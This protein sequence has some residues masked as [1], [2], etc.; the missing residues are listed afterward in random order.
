MAELVKHYTSAMKGIPSL[1]NVWGRMIL[2]LDAVLVDGFNHNTITSLNKSTPNSLTATILLPSDHGFIERQVVRIGGSSNGWD[3]D[4]KVLSVSIDSVTVECTA[5]HPTTI[6]GVA[7]C[8]TAPLD[9]EIV[10]QTPTEDTNRKRAYRSKN[11]DSLGL[12]LLVHDF[13]VTGASA[14]GAKFAKVGVVSD[15]T[16]IET[17]VGSQMPFSEAYPNRNWG[18]D[19][20][21]H[22]WAKWYYKAPNYSS[23]AHTA[24][25]N[26]APNNTAAPFFI[27]GN[28]TSFLIDC[29][30]SNLDS[31]T[32][33]GLVEFD[34]QYINAKNVALLASGI[35]AI[36]PQS[37]GYFYHTRGAYLKTIGPTSYAATNV[38]AI[39]WFSTEGLANYSNLIGNLSITTASTD[40]NVLIDAMVFDSNN[41][42][43]G[44]LP[45]IKNHLSTTN[46]IIY[47]QKVGK[48]VKRYVSYNSTVLQYALTLESE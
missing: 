45:F 3:G 46:E 39:A 8:F 6:S 41:N 28:S 13:C 30:C 27:V 21:Y 32:V 43:R 10:H 42:P 20:T 36:R 24:P 7:T 15:M 1:Y 33:Y 14:T 2:L 12:I 19:G 29:L 37:S 26:Q 47:L 5:E 17:I 11:P 25:D 44:V 31:Y 23:A 34:D 18:W 9:F 38:D 22:G 48:V 16:N 4:Y 35:N 40:K